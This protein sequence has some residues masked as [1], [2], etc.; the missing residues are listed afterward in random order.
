MSDDIKRLYR[1]QNNRMLAGVCAG[2]GEFLGID[3]TLV[4]LL[5]VLLSFMYPGIAL[6]YLMF[7]IVVP[8]APA[9]SQPAPVVPSSE[10]L[11]AEV[12]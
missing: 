8:E 1:S 12:E 5:V 9:Y 6:I 11:D 10:T 4:R 2:L 7:M 3:P